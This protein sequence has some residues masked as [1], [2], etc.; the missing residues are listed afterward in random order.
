VQSLTAKREDL[1]SNVR[2]LDTDNV[3]L[4][5]ALKEKAEEAERFL[6]QARAFWQENIKLARQACNVG[7]PD[8]TR[9]YELT[10]EKERLLTQLCL[11]GTE[12]DALYIQN[13]ELFKHCDDICNLQSG[14]ERE[15][16]SKAPF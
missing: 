5:E 12:R 9:F 14:A 8:L 6:S 1:E 13:A 10:A 3:C 2:T 16:P 15:R 4:N 11:V 7:N